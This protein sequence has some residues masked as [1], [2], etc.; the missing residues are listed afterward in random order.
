MVDRHVSASL[1]A[2]VISEKRRGL[3]S[4]RKREGEGEGGGEGE[5]LE[6]SDQ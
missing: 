2:C 6:E 5:E 4:D 1:R 3:V